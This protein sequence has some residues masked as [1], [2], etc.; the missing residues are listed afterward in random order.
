MLDEPQNVRFASARRA[1]GPLM[2]ALAKEGLFATFVGFLGAAALTASAFCS[3]FR[4]PAL[5]G[6]FG[7][8]S[9]PTT[10]IFQL[11]FQILCFATGVLAFA[12]LCGPGRWR[13][14]TAL[15]W[16]GLGLLLVLLIFPYLV[17]VWDGPASLV[18]TELKS[19]EDE[20]MSEILTAFPDQMNAW[21]QE[22][23]MNGS[24]RILEVMLLRIPNV[25][26]LAV[27]N[28]DRMMY[29]YGYSNEFLNFL[30]WGL[31]LATTACLLLIC[32]TYLVRGSGRFR[33]VRTQAAAFIAG[34]C[35]TLGLTMLPVFMSNYWLREAEV[36]GAEGLYADSLR[37][38]DRAAAWLP[39][40]NLS[41]SY[42]DRRGEML[43][44]MHDRDDSDY[45]LFAGN[46]NFDH[47]LYP[48]A[49]MQYREALRLR[50]DD[51]VALHSLSVTMSNWGIL[52]FTSGNFAGSI[53][54]FREALRISPMNMQALYEIQIAYMQVADIESAR[55]AAQDMLRIH[56]T[57][58]LPAM[59]AI[60]QTYVHL[61][62]CAY[63]TG[64]Y[65]NAF[66]LYRQT[67]EPT[68][69]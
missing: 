49:I 15:S 9:L 30:G 40:I 42:H 27:A 46:Q 64:D 20:L 12:F 66:A 52:Q 29:G 18:A 57:Y 48:E 61:S 44:Q 23:T 54:A 8:A 53:S 69:W 60:G 36:L 16:L 21:K 34:L 38:M 39:I 45:Y 43:Y 65:S 55:R 33:L 67:V 11:P 51:P 56:Q 25:E 37:S 22:T 17:V 62:W 4:L 1:L 41:T 58:R 10:S 32:S 26:Y 68:L 50:P 6:T 7:G 24:D 28:L 31:P 47:N 14:R 35:L 5:H 13:S 2:E 63:R 59:A 19:N 3:W